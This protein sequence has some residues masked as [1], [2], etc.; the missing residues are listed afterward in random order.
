MTQ[1]KERWEIVVAEIKKKIIGNGRMDD[2]AR[3]EIILLL[4]C[5]PTIFLYFFFSLYI[6]PTR[7]KAN[8]CSTKYYSF[9]NYNINNTIFNIKLNWIDLL[10]KLKLKTLSVFI[11]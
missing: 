3:I 10:P 9:V 6:W 7:N 4:R 8:F 2:T 11:C 5:Q 1:N